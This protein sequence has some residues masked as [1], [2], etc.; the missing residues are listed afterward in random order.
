MTK[1]TVSLI[2][3]T[4]TV[5]ILE[6][7][8]AQNF[9]FDTPFGEV[10]GN[11]GDVFNTIQGVTHPNPMGLP[12]PQALAAEVFRN[13]DL[14]ATLTQ[15]PGDA[16]YVPIANAI[17]DGRNAAL[18]SGGHRVPEKVKRALRGFYDESLLDSVRW[19]TD[20]NAV[21][22][23]LQTAQMFASP[24][25]EAITLMNVIIF[26]NPESVDSL[27]NWA[28]EL[29]HVKQYR[30]WGVLQFAKRW[31]NNS[32]VSG[33]VEEP[34]Y[35]AARWITQALATRS[36]DS[37]QPL[38]TTARCDS[39]NNSMAYCDLWAGN[40]FEYV[41]FTIRG[42]AYATGH[43]TRDGKMQLIMVYDGTPCNARASDV[44]GVDNATHLDGDGY[45]CRVRVPGGKTARVNLVAPNS[46]ADATYTRATWSR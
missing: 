36:I 7:A 14:L 40:D 41:T 11:L 8:V 27:E 39:L 9:R 3:F 24:D 25:T 16:V 28:H 10:K 46:R 45:T 17:I 33:P 31:V 34:A 38:Q 2:V 19:S 42:E 12:T 35:S 23:T 30:E 32:S 15:R 20:W 6:T 1:T 29:H 4:A 26:R 22:N 21:R 13:P 37:D 5:L 44:V 18:Q 43:G